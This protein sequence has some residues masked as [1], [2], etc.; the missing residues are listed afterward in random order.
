MQRLKLERGWC[1]LVHC[2]RVDSRQRGPQP[3]ASNSGKMK[4]SVRF[5]RNLTIGNGR[6][7]IPKELSE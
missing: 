3:G 4:Q 1:E 2:P 7:R 6:T 5:P